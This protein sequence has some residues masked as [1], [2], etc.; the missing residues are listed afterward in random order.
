LDFQILK[1]S[2]KINVSGF[3]DEMKRNK[4][5]C[6]RANWCVERE[7]FEKQHQ[8]SN[9]PSTLAALALK[10]GDKSL[11]A[12]LFPKMVGKQEWYWLNSLSISCF[13]NGQQ[14]TIAD[15]L[16]LIFFLLI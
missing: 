16:Q 13:K 12:I 14:K 9:L 11:S 10:R 8:Q 5:S 3:V 15:H 4:K 6:C 1:Q 7:T 2:E